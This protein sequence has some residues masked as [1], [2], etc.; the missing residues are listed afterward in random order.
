MFYLLI[1]WYIT[2]LSNSGL[3]TIDTCINT[4]VLES[5]GIYRWRCLKFS[6]KLSAMSVLFKDSEVQETYAFFEARKLK[7]KQNSV[8][9][10]WGS[11]A[12]FSVTTTLKRMKT[13]WD[14]TSPWSICSGKPKAGV[15]FWFLDF[16]CTVGK[17][18]SFWCPHTFHIQTAQF[19]LVCV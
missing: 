13:P 6:I 7:S 15:T 11:F 19:K 8:F 16:E 18:F 9:F 3:P 17:S 5:G 1:S 2:F 4:F 12:H 10:S 14:T